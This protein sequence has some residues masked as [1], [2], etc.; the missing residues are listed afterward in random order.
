MVRGQGI[1]IQKN[2]PRAIEALRTA[3]DNKSAQDMRCR[4]NGHDHP[5]TSDMLR[6]E[7]IA[8]ILVRGGR[9]V[10]DD[11][12]VIARQS[13]F[14]Y[15]RVYYDRRRRHSTHGYI[16]PEAFEKN[17]FEPARESFKSR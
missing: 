16:S 6:K 10:C 1:G 7:P 3:D 2:I 15:I 9:E 13:I 11:G 5:R 8:G 4:C 17:H 12:R 14:E